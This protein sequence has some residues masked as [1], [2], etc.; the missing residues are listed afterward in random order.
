MKV[1]IGSKITDA[2]DEM[3]MLILDEQDKF[4]LSHMSQEST[5]YCAA[6][7]GTPEKEIAEFMKTPGEDAQKVPTR[8][9]N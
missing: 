1:K 3:I 8:W 4:N 9:S 5:K 6:P 7:E 2:N